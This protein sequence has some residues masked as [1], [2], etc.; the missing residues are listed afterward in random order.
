MSL[1]KQFDEMLRVSNRFQAFKVVKQDFLN[2]FIVNVNDSISAYTG[3][4]KA[5]KETITT[6]DQRIN[7]QAVTIEAKDVEILALNEEKD[8]ISL[9]GISLSKA[10]YSLIMWSAIIGL[11]ALLLLALARMRVAVSA[12]NE[13]G[14]LNTKLTDELEKARK[15]RLEVEQNLRRELQDEINKRSK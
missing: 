10:T 2:A 9:L 7:E 14:A 15:R 5:L 6:Q 8:G 11:L 3:E 13:S 4:I 12:S 1:Q